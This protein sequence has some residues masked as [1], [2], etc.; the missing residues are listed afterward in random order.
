MRFALMFSARMHDAPDVRRA[1]SSAE[2]VGF[3]LDLHERSNELGHHELYRFTLRRLG[4]ILAFDGG[5]LAMGTVE[6]GVPQGHDFV[7]HE[8]PIE[9]MASWEEVKGE[10]RVAL[11]AF[12]NPGRT[13]NFDVRGPIFD[14]CERARGHCQQWG[15]AHVLCTSMISSDAGLFSVM[16]LYRS[17]PSKPFSE[18]D[19]QATELVVPHV[20]SAARRARLGA[21]RAGS[22]VPDAHGQA[23]ALANAA[24]LV[25]EAEPGFVDL[26]RAGW[27]GW[28]GPRLPRELKEV[29]AKGKSTRVVRKPVVVRADAAEQ[30]VL[31]HVRRMVPAD[32]L[33]P[34]ERE[35]AE[36][37]SQGETHREIGARLELSPNT[38]RRHLA[39][40]YEKLGIASKAELD[41][42]IRDV[43]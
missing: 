6:N 37:F 4:A 43:T 35:I 26:V 15:I 39:N 10:D 18:E 13:G 1:P 34:R 22:R 30:C 23:G 28:S 38:V 31:L 42:M 24:G 16:S 40:V 20:F 32:Q 41:K 3:L 33:T 25:F 2:I 14:G 21:L 29:V 7:L 8:R 11:W 5:L 36:A 17:D 19:R 9:L 12:G 27:P